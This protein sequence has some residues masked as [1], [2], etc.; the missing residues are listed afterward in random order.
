MEKLQNV[1]ILEHLKWH[2]KGGRPLQSKSNLNQCTDQWIDM[3]GF[4]LQCLFNL[5]NSQLNNMTTNGFMY[6]IDYVHNYIVLD[7][8]PLVSVLLEVCQEFNQKIE[9][10]G[11]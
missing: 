4:M 7:V 1:E 8:K 6:C 5:D 3:K 9:W 2:C 11:V 10:V